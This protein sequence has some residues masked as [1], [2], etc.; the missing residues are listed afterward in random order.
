MKYSLTTLAIIISLFLVAQF[1]G[2]AVTNNYLIKDELPYGLEPIEMEPGISPWFFIGL[3]VFFSGLMFLFMRKFKFNIIMKFWFFAVVLICM[4]ISLS[5]FISSGIAFLVALSLAILKFKEF[6]VYIHNLG[7]ILVYGGIVVIFA[8]IFNLYAIVI[9]LIL[10][11]LYDYIAVFVTKHMIALAE[12]QQNLGI[13]SGFVVINKGE[14]AVLG[15]GDI[16]FSLLFAAVVL[17]DF[18]MINAIFSVLGAALL[19]S[20]LMVIGKKKKFYPAMPFVTAGC[21]LGFLISI[22]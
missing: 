2:L 22:L 8:P 18:G 4:S 19:I 11:S 9:L 15:G 6:D 7:E 13:F 21:I 5:A 20:I 1:V 3:I 17:R 16:A 12:M 10:I 14:A